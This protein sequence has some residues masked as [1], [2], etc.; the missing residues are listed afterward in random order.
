[1]SFTEKLNKIR[2]FLEKPFFDE[3]EKAF[4][5]DCLT[6][7]TLR[8]YIYPRIKYPIH[9]CLV[10]NKTEPRL[11]AISL[12]NLTSE[13]P[14]DIVRFIL[15]NEFIKYLHWFDFIDICAEVPA[16]ESLRIKDRILCIPDDNN[17]SGY[18]SLIKLLKKWVQHGGEGIHA[19]VD[20]VHAIAPFIPDPKQDE[21]I[22]ARKSKDEMLMIFTSSLKP[23]P[24]FDS[25]EYQ[26]IMA[27]GVRAVADAT[28]MEVCIILADALDKMISLRM[29]PDDLEKSASEGYDGSQFWCQ[30]V[31]S[32]LGYSNA[33]EALVHALTYSCVKVLEKN[34]D[35]YDSLMERLAEKKWNVFRRIQFFL[36]AKFP[37]QTQ[38]LC[39]NF[40]KTNDSYSDGE[41]GVEFAEMCQIACSRFKKDLL[42]EQDW[43]DIFN[44]ILSGP[45][46]QRLQEFLG[47]KFTEENFIKRQAAF[48]KKQFWP[49]ASVLFGDYDKR[50]KAVCFDVADSI[51]LS[52]YATFS[53]DGEAKMIVST[54]PT[55]MDSLSSKTDDELIKF[56]N[57]W[58][59]PGR[60]P[61]EWWVEID[62]SGL[63]RQFSD[64]IKNDVGRFTKWSERWKDLKHPIYLKYALDAATEITCKKQFDHLST[65][66]TLCQR[67][68][69]ECNSPEQA[70]DEK[71]SEISQD[72]PDWS[73]ARMAVADFLKTVLAKECNLPKDHQQVLA[74]LLENLCTG[75]DDRLDTGWDLLVGQ[76][77]PL[78]T[79]I[80]TCRGRALEALFMYSNWSKKNQAPDDESVR[81]ILNARFDGKPALTEPEYAVL[82]VHFYEML[83]I[84]RD[85][86]VLIPTVFP[87]AEKQ[88]MWRTS[89]KSYLLFNNAQGAA[90]ETLKEVLN[91]ALDN[92]SLLQ[93]DENEPKEAIE[94]LGGHLVSYYLWG[95]YELTGENSLIAKYYDTVEPKYYSAPVSYIGRAIKDEKVLESKVYSSLKDRIKSFFEW[96]LNNAMERLNAHPEHNDEYS[97]ELLEFWLWFHCEGL[98]LDWR[99]DT[100]LKALRVCPS[101]SEIRGLLIEDLHKHLEARPKKV[102]EC[103]VEVTKKVNP[104]EYFYL[105]EE[106]AKPILISGL[107]DSELK[108]LAEEARE[109]LLRSGRFEYL[110]LEKV[111]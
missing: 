89:M 65:W 84:C 9:L 12:K 66:F 45:N 96:R 69:S 46:K 39:A 48:H 42:P 31:D 59:N 30:R 61:D 26:E 62:H 70:K 16:L 57:E 103:F 41:Y 7:E 37:D 79:A 60:K 17:R 55:P 44:K 20:L 81:E 86:S 100:L 27:K 58:D 107:T 83:S 19:A 101:P 50:Y 72:K 54:S 33:D 85:G 98:D 105:Q 106:H 111:N 32:P 78:N 82:G 35:K 6:D 52:D 40:I 24:K 92:I 49:F 63:G 13:Y 108:P 18:A 94:S 28:P 110:D 2:S 43:N 8:H 90:F 109:N 80:N 97:K 4:L 56:L 73:S 14:S 23:E 75:Y 15:E 102:L 71:F 51:D 74:D 99:L 68:V 64:L 87:F 77:D 76:K 21:K 47:D 104:T 5:D 25:W 11:A 53:S 38:N 88:D 1:M 29:H 67:I 36:C 95:K 10:T 91:Q 3:N 34:S 22:K 93:K